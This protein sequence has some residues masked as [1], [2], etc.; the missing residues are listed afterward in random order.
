M[1][2]NGDKTTGVVLGVEKE[3]GCRQGRHNPR[4]DRVGVEPGVRRAKIVSQ[5]MDAINSIEL[6]DPKLQDELNRA[7]VA[8]AGA[9][10]QDKKPVKI[11]FTGPVN[12]TSGWGTSSRPRSGKPATG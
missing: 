5:P 9:R 3:A 7:L 2:V 4:R 12:G 6:D 11:N 8:L 1:T 10:D